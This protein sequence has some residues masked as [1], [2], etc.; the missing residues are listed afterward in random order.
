MDV[1]ELKVD[2]AEI[3]QLHRAYKDHQHFETEVDREIRQ[4]YAALAKGQTVISA[5]ASVPKAGIGDDKLPKLALVRADVPTCFIEVPNYSTGVVRM[6]PTREGAWGYS[7]RQR[8]SWPRDVFPG[9]K[10]GD[11]QAI[12]PMIPVNLRPRTALDSYHIL[13]E[14]EWTRTVPRDPYLL[15]RIGQADLWLVVAA[16]NLTEV[17]RAVLQS[18]VTN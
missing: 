15:R 7:K 16:W 6:A 17:E 11:Y 5:L 18:R 4:T 1:A 8:F 14:A 12:V 3:E 13:F 2:P 10:V 9:I